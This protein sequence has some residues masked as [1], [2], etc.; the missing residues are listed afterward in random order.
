MSEWLVLACVVLSITTI[1]MFERGSFWKSMAK[2]EEGSS[3]RAW[4]YAKRV[5]DRATKPTRA[6]NSSTR[7]TRGRRR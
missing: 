1:V 4:D 5:T 2:W 3:A 6:G 7:K